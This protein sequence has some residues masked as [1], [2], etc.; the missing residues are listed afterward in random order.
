MKTQVYT[1]SGTFELT[2]DGWMLVPENRFIAFIK[3]LFRIGG[4]K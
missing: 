4:D 2:P 1:M 3:R